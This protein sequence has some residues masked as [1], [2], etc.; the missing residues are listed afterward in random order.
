MTAS[1]AV[2]G[3]VTGQFQV[4]FLVFAHGHQIGPVEKDVG[5]HQ[6]WVVQQAH[7]HLVT[8]LDG[9][10]LELDHALQPVERRDA[11]QEPAQFAV[12]S[13]MALHKNRGLAWINAAGEIEG[14]R[15]QRV[16]GQLA[17]VVRNGDGM[18]V[19][20]TEKGVVAVLQVDPI[21]DRSQPVP[22][23]QRTRGLNP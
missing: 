3:N 21:A 14:R 1:N 20:D 7:G 16:L 23:V 18:Q 12:G 11:I 2:L 9:L 19:H 5:R 8:L 10:L 13:H 22:Q 6:D 4:L 17:G 15:R